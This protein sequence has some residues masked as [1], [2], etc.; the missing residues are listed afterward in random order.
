L[1]SLDLN[2]KHFQFLVI[3]PALGQDVASTKLVDKLEGVDKLCAWKYRIPLIPEE[4]DLERFI[5]EN[6]PKPTDVEAKA[7]HQKDRVKAKRIIANSIKD[8]LIP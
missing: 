7:K 5:K 2:S 3:L 4:N 8:H 6:V 1:V